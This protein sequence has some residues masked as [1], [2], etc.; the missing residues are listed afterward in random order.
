VNVIQ[1]LSTGAMLA[2]SLV[3]TVIG[4]FCVGVAAEGPLGRGRRLVGFKLWEIGL[5]R[6]V[7]VFVVGL[8]FLLVHGL[9]DGVVAGLPLPITTGVAGIRAV[10]VAG[11]TVMPLIGVPASLAARW[12]PEGPTWL[13]S[14]DLPIMFLVW[15]VATMAIVS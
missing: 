7:A 8:L 13:R 12:F 3:L 6:I 9:V 5:G 14:A 2:S 4:L 15:A 10:G 1:D 11:M